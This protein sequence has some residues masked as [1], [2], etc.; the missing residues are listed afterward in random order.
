MKRGEH[1]QPGRVVVAVA[2][3]LKH[4]TEYFR[5]QT[6]EVSLFVP[7]FYHLVRGLLGERAVFR[8]YMS[9]GFI[10]IYDAKTMTARTLRDLVTQ[11]LALTRTYEGNVDRAPDGG[12]FE[13]TAEPSHLPRILG[14]GIAKGL[15][16]GILDGDGKRDFVSASMN[17]AMKLADE[18]KDARFR[19]HVLVHDS[20]SVE[21]MQRLLDRSVGK[22]ELNLDSDRV[23]IWSLSDPERSETRKQKQRGAEPRPQRI[24]VFTPREERKVLPVGSTPIDFAYHVHSDIGHT[25]SGARVNGRVVPL[26]YQLQSGDVVE[27]VTR[28]DGRPSARWLDFARTAKAREKI[29]QWFRRAEHS[30]LTLFDLRERQL[31]KAALS[32]RVRRRLP[33]RRQRLSR[34]ARA[35]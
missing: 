35:H 26:S 13:F 25:T 12:I 10:F 20:V 34:R 28:R 27:I 24:D 18:A 7:A 31:T 32:K 1:V 23:K 11:S 33:V 8:T 19:S 30:E 29:R 17:T 22:I 21:P 16:W 4:S 2:G 5:D 9:D 6:S 3:D 15:G 14:I